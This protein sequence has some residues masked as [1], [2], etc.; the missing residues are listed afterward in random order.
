MSEVGR[1]IAD[2]YRLTEHIGSGAMGVVWQ[3][4]DERLHRTV[5]LKQLLLQP[6]LSAADAHEARE[7]A[8]REGRIAAR[9]QHPN[10][11]AVYDV[12]E[13]DSQ[14]VL[15]MEYV[16]SQSLSAV[17]DARG[18]LPP[19]EVARIGAQVA[20]A[21]TA[22]HQAGIVHRDI[23]PGNVLLADD[24]T[25]KITDFGISRATGDVTVTATGMLAGTPAYLAPEVA[26]G[27][28]PGPPSDVFSLA[29][30]MY[31]AVEG[32]PPFGLGENTLALLHA[33]AACRTMPPRQ[34]G[35]LTA[36]LMHM[37]RANPN[38]RPTMSEVMRALS[39]I[40]AGQTAG[41]VLGPSTGPTPMPMPDPGPPTPPRPEV[42]PSTVRTWQP[43]VHHAPPTPPRPYQVRPQGRPGG[44]AGYPGQSTTAPPWRKRLL[45]ALAIVAAALIGILV[46][47]AF[48]DTSGDNA[49]LP[50][51]GLSTADPSMADQP[52]PSALPTTTSTVFTQVSTDPTTVDAPPAGMN[53]TP[54][55][56]AESVVLHT[57]F[58]LLP[59]QSAQ[60]FQLL[61]P[62][63]QAASGG[64]GAYQQTWS[65]V[66]NVTLG[67]ILPHGAGHVRAKVRVQPQNGKATDNTYEFT[68]VEQNGAVLIDNVAVVGKAGRHG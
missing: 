14:P 33:V 55:F 7:R 50:S 40:A 25:V 8:M 18:P 39:A 11:V 20:T 1:L 28:S 26:K 59:G 12:V 19:Q 51:L 65:T 15:I 37:L 3:A 9:L 41:P 45:T 64:L 52:L 13:D 24:G 29:S 22:A 43:Q 2:R 17:L 27:E 4:H 10:A 56:G 36:L 21:L 35:P 38:D 6:G 31:A 16:P 46:A 66:R 54:T 60:S 44:P 57:Y 53:E 47:N 30:T 63:E 5:A 58:G 48:V 49:S 61:T 34:A 42:D 23:K 67:A 68:F 32:H 62:K